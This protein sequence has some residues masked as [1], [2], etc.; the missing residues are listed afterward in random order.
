MLRPDRSDCEWIENG[1]N[2]KLS[3]LKY[4]DIWYCN[5]PSTERLADTLLS[6]KLT[7]ASLKVYSIYSVTIYK[8]GLSFLVT[9]MEIPLKATE[10]D[11]ALYPEIEVNRFALVGEKKPN[12]KQTNI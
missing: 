1:K 5:V 8:T 11:L 9:P 4:L 12:I 6:C 3:D 2:W 10:V 7:I